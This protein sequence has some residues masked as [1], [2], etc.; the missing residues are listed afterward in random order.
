MELDVY[1]CVKF[2]P[3]TLEDNILLGHCVECN[4]KDCPC[5]NID[6]TQI[7]K[8]NTMKERNA[9]NDNETE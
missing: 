7:T 8:C 5:Y 6:T 3:Y 2:P 4:N 9:T 1:K